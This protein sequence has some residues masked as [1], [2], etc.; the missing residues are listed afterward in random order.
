MSHPDNCPSCSTPWNHEE[1]IFDHFLDRYTKEGI[2]DSILRRTKDITLKQAAAETAGYY[3]DTLETPRHFGKDVIGIE[4]QGEYDGVLYWQCQV[5][6]DYT[7]RF[8][9]EIFSKLPKT[10]RR[11]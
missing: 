9:G 1:T 8:N 11:F 5:C 10:H 4:I 2:P 7:H 6:G 3:G